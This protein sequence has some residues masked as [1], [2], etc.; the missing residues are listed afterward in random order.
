ML[1]KFLKSSDVKPSEI[2]P[3]NTYL[4][5]REF[6]QD[7]A[8]IGGGIAA[9][10]AL[11]T[12]FSLQSPSAHAQVSGK[13]LPNIIRDGAYGTDERMTSY[14]AVT[15]YN[16]FY[17]FGTAKDDPARHAHSLRPRPWTVRVDGHVEN[18]GDYDIDDLIKPHALQE[19]IYRMRCVEAWSMVIP[20]VG[21][22]LADVI[23][24]MN[25]AGNAKYVA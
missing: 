10:A 11:G 15:G 22:P 14:K 6:I 8:R 25:P 3:E 20:W 2:T 1:F 24:R 19:R 21:I 13:L 18:P 16:N 5:R 9:S 17:E 7:T 23:K 4:N 12:A